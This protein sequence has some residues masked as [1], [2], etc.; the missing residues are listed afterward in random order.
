MAIKARI[1][2]KKFKIQM[3]NG[4]QFEICYLPFD[5]LVPYGGGHPSGR[6]DPKSLAPSP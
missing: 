6:A 1:R 4:K 3:A 2:E 5:L